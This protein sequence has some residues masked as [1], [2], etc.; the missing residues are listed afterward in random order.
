MKGGVHG[1]GISREGVFSNIEASGVKSK[2]SVGPGCF[3]FLSNLWSVALLQDSDRDKVLGLFSIMTGQEMFRHLAF[4]N[5]FI[6]VG[7]MVS[8]SKGHRL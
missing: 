7:F 1:L 8:P 3:S 5:S 6:V 4:V 2:E